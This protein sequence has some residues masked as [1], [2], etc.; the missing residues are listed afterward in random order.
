MALLVALLACHSEV[1]LPAGSATTPDLVLVSVDTLRADHVSAYGYSRPTTPFLDRLAA[2]GARATHA[3][4]AAP[5]TLPSHTTML[6][7]QLPSTHHVIEDALRLDPS[8]P[9]LPELLRGAGYQTGGFVATMYVSRVFGFERGFDRFED[10]D[11]HT[12]KANLSGEVTADEVVD[13]AL[14]WLGGLPAGQ[15][16]F[17][18]LHVYDAHYAYDPPAPYN[19]LFDRAPRPS[20]FKYRNYKYYKSHPVDPEQMAHQTAQYDEAIRYVDD[21]LARLH[22]AL[23]AAGR[24]S[25]WVVT[26]DHGEELGERGSWG[27][28]HTLYAEQLRVP[29]ILWGEGVPAGRVLDGVV[30]T[31]DVAPTLLGLAGATGLRADGIDLGPALAGAAL[32]ERAFLAETSRFDSNRIGLY[33]GGLRLEWDLGGGHQ[34]LYDAVADPAEKQDVRVDRPQDLAAV[35]DHTLAQVGQP[36]TALRA[37]LV[38]TDGQI[39]PG[40]AR[41]AQVTAGQTFA[42]LPVDAK[43]WFREDAGR[44]GPWARVGGAAP[45]DGDPLKVAAAGGAGSATLT[46]AQRQALEALGYVQE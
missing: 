5:W 3:R 17:V 14:G 23:A 21:Q 9:V 46:E 24:R 6:T 20:D 25:R 37:G 13:A 1:R 42:V 2:K 38:E 33:D 7:G 44:R 29:L 40:G 18:F 16:A 27:H 4:S 45:K 12:E 41:Q 15:P 35:I 8:T 22:A 43:V 31:Q 36:W 26:A 39:L 19:T 28:A 10:F 32:P 11:L 34:E 30:G